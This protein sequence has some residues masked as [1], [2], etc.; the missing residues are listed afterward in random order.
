MYK[1]GFTNVIS[2]LLVLEFNNN[3]SIFI[4][5]IESS[6]RIVDN[7]YFLIFLNAYRLFQIYNT[8]YTI[9]N[10]FYSGIFNYKLFLLKS[11]LY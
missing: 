4:Q 5:I 9:R 8:Y 11:I 10:L 3:Y 1:N 2:I 6:F 7:Y